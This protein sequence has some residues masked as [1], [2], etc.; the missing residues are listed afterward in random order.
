MSIENDPLRAMQAQA[1]LAVIGIG[2][3]GLVGLGRDA[4]RAIE[5]AETLFGGSRHLAL[6]P[7]HTGQ[8]RIVWPSPLE[9]AL[10]WIERRR[11]RPVCVL[12]SGD[13]CW[14]G[15]GATLA[16]HLPVAEM[17]IHPTASA[18]SLAAA[19]LGWALQDTYCLSLHGRAMERIL[20]CLHGGAKILAL[21]WDGTTPKSLGRLLVERG[22][23]DAWMTVL[24]Y[25][26]GPR[27]QRDEAA[28]TD[29]VTS[30]TPVAALNTVAIDCGTGTSGKVIATAPGRPESCFDNDGLI[31]KREVRAAVLAHLSPGHGECLWD[32]GAGSGAV[33]I[34]WML[35]GSGNQTIAVESR[36]ERAE[37]VRANARRLGVP[38]LKCIQGQAPEVLVGLTPPDAVFIGGGV[39]NPE[40][41]EV[42]HDALRSG[43]RLV[44]TAV[45]LEA[46]A[47]LLAY[48]QRWGGDL[49][50]MQ[51]N[52][53]EPLGDFSGWNPVRPV[54]LW[55]LTRR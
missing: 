10:P 31:T 21:S 8:E 22:F 11:G 5:D 46:E 42:C 48:R 39:S 40:L 19:R 27:E 1:W 15:I 54:T 9:Q 33:G 25:M 36:P 35:A 53:S 13:P 55:I 51:V 47:I 16:Q 44:V 52:R 30:D 28:A 23:G 14:Y 50:R 2:E 45:T 20:P 32:I 29:W 38:D 49:V 24:S 43:G 7:E 41:L 4:R 17:V 26:G 3:D 34:E 12:A 18:F 37:R 6:I